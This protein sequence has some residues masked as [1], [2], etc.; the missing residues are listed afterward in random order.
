MNKVNLN[1]MDFSSQKT[2]TDEN[3]MTQPI[4]FIP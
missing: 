2:R 1:E 3:Y 4:L